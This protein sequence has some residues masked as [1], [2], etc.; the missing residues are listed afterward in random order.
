MTSG[1]KYGAVKTV[2]SAGLSAATCGVVVNTSSYPI[3]SHTVLHPM[4]G[5]TQIA[6]SAAAAAAA[7]SA[8]AVAA[9]NNSS[10]R[11][12]FKCSAPLNGG[13]SLLSFTKFTSS[14]SPQSQ[15]SSS[16]TNSVAVSTGAIGHNNGLSL[17]LIEP[18]DLNLLSAGT[19]TTLS[20]GSTLTL[21]SLTDL[22][23]NHNNSNNNNGHNHSS[24]GHNGN[25]NV[26]NH[27]VAS[28]HGHT[29][30]HMTAAAVAAVGVNGM[31]CNAMLNSVSSGLTTC[32]TSGS[33]NGTACNSSSNSSSSP[34]LHRNGH[35]NL[36]SNLLQIGT[37][38]STVMCG[39]PSAD[40]MSMSTAM[41][42]NGKS[43]SLSLSLS[44][45]CETTK[46]YVFFVVNLFAFHLFTS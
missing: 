27:T 5:S 7:A 24:N 14:S 42:F 23:N 33:T 40:L 22:N 35:L 44:V 36:N 8:A 28:L 45:F 19:P 17:N 12:S 3:H 38:S 18:S 21:T 39:G 2:S 46:F 16:I 15:L 37:K 34:L 11:R 25:N 10:M 9:A 20:N 31:S 26:H 30:A 13:S 4:S 6:V 1:V 41:L 43:V 29:H 32:P